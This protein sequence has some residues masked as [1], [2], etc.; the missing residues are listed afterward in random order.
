MGHDVDAALLATLLVNALRRARRA[1]CDAAGQADQAHQAMLDHG[2]GTF[3]TGQ[4][5]RISLDSRRAQLV[6]AG[7]PWPLRLSEQAVGFF[8]AGDDR[9]G[10]AYARWELSWPAQRHAAARHGG[11]VEPV[12]VIAVFGWGSAHPHLRGAVARMWPG[13]V[14]DAADAERQEPILRAIVE[15]ELHERIF[16]GTWQVIPAFTGQD[17]N[18]AT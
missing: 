4:L 16:Q 12:Q 14:T 7:H 17:A 10:G 6:N 15:C 1:G 13:Q 8:R 3:A 11:R 18:A 5:L 9:D 2:H